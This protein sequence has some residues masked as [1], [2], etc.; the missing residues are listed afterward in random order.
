MSKLLGAKLKEPSNSILFISKQAFGLLTKREKTNTFAVILIQIF[1][2]LLDLLGVVLF[3]ILGSLTINGL[4]A[5]KPGDKS[6]FVLTQ[7]NIDD[8]PLQQQV[9]FIALFGTILLAI[10]TFFHFISQNVLYIF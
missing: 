2:S 1:L 9:I 8:K 7:L 10:K 6:M 4:T 5:K 3:G